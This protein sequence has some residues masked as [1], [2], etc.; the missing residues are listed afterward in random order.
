MNAENPNTCLVTISDA[1]FSIGTEVL[2][3]SIHKF[4]PDFDGDI[5]VICEDLPDSDRQRI[6][7]VS[8]ARFQAP[9]DRLRQA[10]ENLRSHE[11][12]LDDIYRRLFSLEAFRFSDYDRVVY[13][14]SDIY[15]Q[16]DI[17]SLFAADE[18]LLACAD[19]FTYA[20]RIDERLSEGEAGQLRERYGRRMSGSF[21][22]GVLSISPRKLGASIYEELLSWLEPERWKSMGPGKFTD[23]MLLNIHFNGDFACLEA[24]YNYMVFLEGYQKI[25]EGA[26][27]VDARL[28]HFAGSLKP[29]FEYEPEMLAR[30]APQCF[31]AFDAWRELLDQARGPID[32]EE[33]R[34]RFSAHQDWISSYNSNPIKPTGRIY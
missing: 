32:E 16:G 9:D 11:P 1:E 30:R 14:D 34:R 20:D 15:C 12:R 5:V 3:Y 6:A 19:G 10:V 13:L 31:K 7:S 23:Q 4:N 24:I 8:P 2:L 18:P 29:W 26:A 25:A 33:T 28:V 17:S 21:N 22:A 27:F